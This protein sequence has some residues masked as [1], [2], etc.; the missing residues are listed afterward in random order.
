M[1]AAMGRG[2]G[3][4]PERVVQKINDEIEKIGQNA[5][6]R[7]I[8]IPL[9]S[10]QKYMVG[11]AEPS[12]VTLEKIASYFRVSVAWLRGGAVGL[13][14]RFIDG[15]N[16]KGID[17]TMFNIMMSKEMGKEGDY[18]SEIIAGNAVSSAAL[19][20][21]MCFYF[22]INYRWIVEGN[23]PALMG[24]GGL[25][26]A[27]T[28]NPDMQIARF[29]TRSDLRAGSDHPPRAE[30]IASWLRK[31]PELRRMV[32]KLLAADPSDSKKD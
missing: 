31:D 9:R 24:G 23:Q 20:E 7:A 4:T 12:Q 10:V 15:L 19:A 22:G 32:E 29:L 5:T 14:E 13:V 26:G 16:M 27:V 30:D 2:G 3:K 21:K 17:P 8:G 6:A 25:V 11:I 18:W 1:V 28:V